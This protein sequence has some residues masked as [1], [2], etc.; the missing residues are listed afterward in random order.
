MALAKETTA[1][2][3]SKFGASASD[4]G[5]VKVQVALLTERIKELTEHCK[6]FPKDTGA[7]RGLL[8]C[9]GQR[10]KMLKYY[11]RKDLEGYRALIKELGIRK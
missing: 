1:S 4:T 6:Q 2:I 9:V 5:N 3:V 7:A 10:R 11:Q 8:K